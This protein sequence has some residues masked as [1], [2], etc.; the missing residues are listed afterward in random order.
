[1]TWAGSSCPEGSPTPLKGSRKR[2]PICLTDCR[3]P[4]CSLSWRAAMDFTICAAPLQPFSEA[5]RTSPP[6]SS[7]L[8]WRSNWPLGM[9]S[10]SSV[11]S[12]PTSPSI[13]ALTGFA[14][15]I[16]QCIAHTQGGSLYTRGNHADN[17]AAANAFG[18]LPVY[19]GEPPRISVSQST[20]WVYPREGRGRTPPGSHSCRRC[21][22]G[23]RRCP[24]QGAGQPV[25]AVQDAGPGWLAGSAQHC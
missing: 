18:W 2:F 5:C 20:M 15:A 24:S 25:G 21:W 10:M 6:S 11:S 4:W 1:M 9:S 8:A 14:Q 13:P 23:L 7:S 19:A 16:I 17:L 22:L 12:I 3:W